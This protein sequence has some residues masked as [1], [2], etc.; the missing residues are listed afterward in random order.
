[1]FF[2]QVWSNDICGC[3]CENSAVNECTQMDMG[4]DVDCQCVDVQAF[5][6]H[7]SGKKSTCQ[8]NSLHENLV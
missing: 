8:T 4:I 7:K 3:R 1:M 6:D 5:R 2:P